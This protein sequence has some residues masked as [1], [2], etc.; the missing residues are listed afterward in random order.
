M[1]SQ[2]R[3]YFLAFYA[4]GI[5]VL[6]GRVL[7]A[8]R[9]LGPVQYRVNDSR[10]YVPAIFLLLDWALPFVLILTRIGEIPRELIP[11]RVVG[12][13]LSVFAAVANLWAVAALGR[14]LVPQAVVL[15]DHKL[16][17][18][19]PYQFVRH[20]AYSGD[21]ALFLGS[22]LGTLNVFLL[23]LWPVAVIGNLVQARIEEQ[24]LEAR[25]GGAYRSYVERTGRFL[26]RF[27]A[28]AS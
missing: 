28:R 14:Y 3:V 8:A 2:I 23:V 10:R 24:L 25:F 4:I 9:N 1:T 15:T 19:G 18:E 11:I 12:L 22:A 27:W 5:A 26:P 16:V 6:L 20:P 7:P 17:T 13:L 21:L